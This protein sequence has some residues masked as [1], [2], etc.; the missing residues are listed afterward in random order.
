E[1]VHAGSGGEDHRDQGGGGRRRRCQG[2]HLRGGGR[3]EAPDEV[4]QKLMPASWRAGRKRLVATIASYRPI[5]TIIAL[6]LTAALPATPPAQTP[7]HHSLAG[8]LL[9]ASPTIGDPRFDR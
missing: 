8:Q 5:A 6:L 1:G 2:Q 4:R 3:P 9:I 7:P